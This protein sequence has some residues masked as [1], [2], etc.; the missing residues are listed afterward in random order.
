MEGS[1]DSIGAEFVK[2][3]GVFKES[4]GACKKL[5]EFKKKLL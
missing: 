2:K 5:L 3:F 4:V 1:L